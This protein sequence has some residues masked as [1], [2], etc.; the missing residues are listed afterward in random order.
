MTL[1]QDSD[2]FCLL[3]LGLVVLTSYIFNFFFVAISFPTTWILVA[4]YLLFLVGIPLLLIFF[5]TGYFRP[6]KGK[7]KNTSMS[8]SVV[9][10]FFFVVF[11]YLFADALY[12]VL[13]MSPDNT[14]FYYTIWGLGGSILTAAGFSIMHTYEE[15]TTPG[16]LDTSALRYAPEPEPEPEPEAEEVAEGEEAPA[17]AEVVTEE[18]EGV[19]EEVAEVA[20]TESE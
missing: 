5:L 12:V 1:R 11:A 19:K 3:L 17:E 2:P 14:G 7:A 4:E 16:I 9:I 6:E 8:I 18:A 10:G 13:S 15:S 20:E